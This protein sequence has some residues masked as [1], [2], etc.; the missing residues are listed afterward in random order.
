MGEDFGQQRF[1]L[2]PVHN[3]DAGHACG[4]S[5]GRIARFGNHFRRKSPASRLEKFL[6][7]RHHHV[8]N[9]LAVVMQTV[10]WGDENQLYR[11]QRDCHRNSDVIGVDPVRLALGAKADGRNDRNN[12]LVQQG[13]ENRRC[14]SV[15][16]S[17]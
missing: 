1:V 15:P 11:L 13:F 17:P 2:V 7:V 5:G 6:Q 3:V 9:E 8:A 16:P 10:L 4:T 12:V 14:Q